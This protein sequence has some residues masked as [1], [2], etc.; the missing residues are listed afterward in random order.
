[1]SGAAKSVKS[2]IDPIRTVIG[3]GPPEPE[4]TPLADQANAKDPNA[5]PSRKDVDVQSGAREAL[6]KTRR[7]NR[8]PRRSPLG[9]TSVAPVSVKTLLGS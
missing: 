1:M 7:Q 8:T 6:R 3:I 5:P 9:D 4:T 2:I